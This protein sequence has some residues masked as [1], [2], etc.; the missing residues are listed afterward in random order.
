MLFQQIQYPRVL[1]LLLNNQSYH[2]TNRK[3]K[4]KERTI[5]VPKKYLKKTLIV[6]DKSFF[7]L[8]KYEINNSHIWFKITNFS[9]LFQLLTIDFVHY[10][11]CTSIVLSPYTF[12]SLYI[13]LLK[14][15][16][17]IFGQTILALQ[18]WH[19][20]C[21]MQNFSSRREE[22]PKQLDIILLIIIQRIN[23]RCHRTYPQQ[24]VF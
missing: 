12:S 23:V 15:L 16:S 6:I 2:K 19:R 3:T 14:C 20:Y 8:T 21:I 1:N 18:N 24:T 17:S 5:K 10:L 13:T 4:H 7:Y 9:L 11:S 22:H